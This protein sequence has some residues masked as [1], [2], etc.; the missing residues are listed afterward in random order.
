MRLGDF[1]SFG[2]CSGELPTSWRR[3]LCSGF[4]LTFQVTAGRRAE[5][6]A[7]RQQGQ[8]RGQPLLTTLTPLLRSGV[9]ILPPR[10]HSQHRGEWSIESATASLAPWAKNS[11]EHAPNI[12]GT[13]TC[14]PRAPADF[15]AARRTRLRRQHIPDRSSPIPR[16]HLSEQLPSRIPR[17]RIWD[18]LTIARWPAIRWS[19][20][21]ERRT[22]GNTRAGIH[23][24]E[25]HAT[26]KRH[27]Q[28]GE[29]VSRRDSRPTR[30]RK[31]S[32]T[33]TRSRKQHFSVSR[34]H[35]LDNV[36]DTWKTHRSIH[37]PP[38]AITPVRRE[39]KAQP[40]PRY[41]HLR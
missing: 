16:R 10:P 37:P 24:E 18:G 31:I 38:G 32:V 4:T 11:T 35:T 28:P 25:E 2:N 36:T 5:R 14:P 12:S 40:W 41:S 3:P 34:R 13:T 33:H 21:E 30:G 23:D 26:F 29:A 1:P 8:K 39:R 7:R 22:R 15:L 27:A 17:R 20:T 9:I 19:W 6:R